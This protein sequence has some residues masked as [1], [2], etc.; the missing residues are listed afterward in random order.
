MKNE[1]AL[2]FILGLRLALLPASAAWAP[3]G[4]MLAQD[5][6]TVRV[7][8]RRRAGPGGGARERAKAPS[9][10]RSGAGRPPSGTGSGGGN[11]GGGGTGGGSGGSGG[12][13]GSMRPSGG[14]MPGG[15]LGLIG[16]IIVVILGVVFGLPTFTSQDTPEGQAG[17]VITPLATAPPAANTRS[18]A[19]TEQSNPT[20]TRSVAGASNRPAATTGETW[21]VMLYQDADDKVLEKDIYVDLNEAERVGSTDNVHIVAQLDRYSGGYQADGD[22]TGAKRFYVTQDDDL[23]QVRS[24]VVADLGE[25]NMADAATLVDFVTWAMQTYPAD[26]YALILSDHGMGWPGGWSDPTATGGGDRTIPLAAK[27]SDMLYLNEI[28]QA[29]AEIRQSAGLDKFDVLGLDA[30]LMAHLEVFAALEPH[31]RFAVASQE[32]EPALGWAYTSFLGA[33]V[34]NPAMDGGELSQH[35]LDSYITDDQRILDDRERA[36]LVGRGQPMGGL[37]DI[38]F[39]GATTTTPSAEQV[40]T[41][42][43]QN[44]TLTAM[45]LAALPALMES[46]NNFADTLQ[47][48]NQK[49]V[50]QAR[51]YAQSYTSIFGPQVPASYIDLGHFAQLFK[52][53]GADG[54][55]G[56]SVDSLLAALDQAVIGEKH[57]PKRPGATGVSIYFPVSQLYRTPEAGPQSY[58]AVADR[59]A[60]ESLWDDFLVYHYTGREFEAATRSAALPERTANIRGPA[61]GGVTVSPITLSDNS[62]APGRP[63]L[64]TTHIEGENV[65]YVYLFTGFY[66]SVANSILTI[67]MDYLESS[68]SGELN[69]VYYPIWPQD[70]S[71]NL[72]FEWEPLV[73]AISDGTTSATTLFQPQSYG[74]LPENAIYTVEGTYTFGDDGETRAARLYFSDGVLRQVFGFAGEEDLG[75]PSEITPQTGDR[76][77]IQERWL[78]LDASGAVVNEVIEAG[79]TLTFGDQPFT[80]QEQ[81]AAAGSYLVGFIVEDLDGNKTHVYEQINVE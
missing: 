14:Q 46:V 57:G 22:W 65:G 7:Q 30:C 71:F 38:L 68:E 26:K 35:I 70:N 48:V 45:D 66:D 3:S 50:A 31:A 21:T 23:Q 44:I 80:W 40:A 37:F 51:G 19:T 53:A 69:G 32:T 29:L 72:E 73:F 16:I 34:N 55:L 76:F 25:V 18:T 56:Q 62:A 8:R 27:L 11:L 33:L 47:T 6:D 81:D 59:F 20:P 28:D 1:F 36:D 5:D 12:L 42:L 9:R 60:Q 10:Q 78:D 39:G 49:S 52:Q 24:Q 74:A 41:E 77:T 13:G 64:L 79:E 2:N 58:T 15:G 43:G 17:T 61:S 75:A 63:V 67:D 4:P 54:T